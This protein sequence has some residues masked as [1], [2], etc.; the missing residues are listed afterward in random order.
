MDDTLRFLHVLEDA[1]DERP[2]ARVADYRLFGFC[3]D[4][5]FYSYGVHGTVTR[6]PGDQGVER[7][8]LGPLGPAICDRINLAIER[9]CKRHGLDDELLGRIEYYDHSAAGAFL[10]RLLDP[11]DV[12]PIATIRAE[13]DAYEKRARERLHNQDAAKSPP[14]NHL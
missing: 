10:A 12:D 4:N 13:V 9:I 3:L 1:A 5:D 8:L 6:E 7:I 2:N 11:G 14:A